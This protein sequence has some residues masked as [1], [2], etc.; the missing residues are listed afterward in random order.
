MTKY[1]PRGSLF[2]NKNKN[3]DDRRPDY[4]GKLE[5]NDELVDYLRSKLD[6]GTFD[7]DYPVLEISAWVRKSQKNGKKW[8]SIGLQVPYNDRAGAGSSSGA[9]GRATRNDQASM[10]DDDDIPF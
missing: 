7:G 2:P 9:S 1:P 6:T 10:I 5:L 8:I 3:G 4:Q